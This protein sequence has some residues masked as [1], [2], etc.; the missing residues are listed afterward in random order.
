MTRVYRTTLTGFFNLIII[1]VSELEAG[2][3]VFDISEFL[4]PYFFRNE[5]KIY[6]KCLNY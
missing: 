4:L 3:E 5:H 1:F 2:S 6:E